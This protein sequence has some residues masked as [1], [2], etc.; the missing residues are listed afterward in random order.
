MKNEKYYKES[1]PKTFSVW[2]TFS[3]SDKKKKENKDKRCVTEV[4]DSKSKA[5][6]NQDTAH[7]AMAALGV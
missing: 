2:K 6:S 3:F 7:N 4:L 5:V 1:H